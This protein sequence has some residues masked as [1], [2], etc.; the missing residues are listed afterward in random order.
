MTTKSTQAADWEE[1][2]N[3]QT[4][5]LS[6]L[7][8][9]VVRALAETSES[10]VDGMATMVRELADFTRLRLRQDADFGQSLADC[11]EWSD[12]ANMQ[13]AW[14]RR[15]TQDYLSEVQKLAKLGNELM[16]KSWQPL[17]EGVKSTSAPPAA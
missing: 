1:A 12:A 10:Y 5:I 14:A 15:A 11:K 2:A 8:G 17:Y 9:T 7:N 16:L 6:S 3:T 13:Q 4:A